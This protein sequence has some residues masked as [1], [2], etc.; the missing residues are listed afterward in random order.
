MTKVNM[1]RDLH[2]F[3][4]TISNIL[5]WSDNKRH[6]PIRTNGF[7]ENVHNITYFQSFERKNQAFH[8]NCYSD[9]FSHNKRE[10]IAS[11]FEREKKMVAK[12]WV[13]QKMAFQNLI[14]LWWFT[15]SNQFREFLWFQEQTLVSIRSSKLDPKHSKIVEIEVV[16]N[17][18]VGTTSDIKTNEKSL[19][20]ST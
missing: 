13:Q 8:S 10:M 20:K 11:S 7:G 17:E 2:S 12:C 16:W 4:S 19:L 14:S 6:D 3:F 1:A 9:F 5:N 18:E 15:Q